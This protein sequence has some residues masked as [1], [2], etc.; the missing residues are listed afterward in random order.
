MKE[1][2]DALRV[3]LLEE[4]EEIHERSPKSI[5]RPCRHHVDLAAGHRLHEGIKARA[6]FDDLFEVLTE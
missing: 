5:D 6:L 1:Q 3:K 4:F 2:V